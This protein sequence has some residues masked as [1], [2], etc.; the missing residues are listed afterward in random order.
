MGTRHS[1]FAVWDRLSALQLDEYSQSDAH[2]VPDRPQAL[3]M[4]VAADDNPSWPHQFWEIGSFTTPHVTDGDL[5]LLPNAS[6]PI[7]VNGD[8]YL[9]ILVGNTANPFADVDWPVQVFVNDG[10]GHFTDQTNT[11]FPSGVPQMNSGNQGIVA[12]FNGDGR[13]DVF[14]PNNNDGAIE[15]TQNGLFLSSGEHGF[16][17]GTP[18][19]PQTRDFTHGGSATDID[20]DG[21]IDILLNNLGGDG[22][23]P[24][25]AHYGPEF[26]L[27]D[28]SGHFTLD[29]AGR[30]P[31]EIGRD[32]NLFTSSTF[33]D[34]DNDG[35]Q[36]LIL[37]GWGDVGYLGSRINSYLLLNDGTGHFSIREVLPTSK[38]TLGVAAAT[39]AVE[40]VDLNNDGYADLVSSGSDYAGRELIEFYLNDRHGKLALATDDVVI[41]DFN[42]FETSGSYFL[43]IVDLNNDGFADI[44]TTDQQHR[45]VFLNDGS[46]HFKI[47]PKDL[48]PE[49]PNT[50]EDLFY[51][52][53]FGDLNNDGRTDMIAPGSNYG[54]NENTFFIYYGHDMPTTQ[55]GTNNADTILGD[56]DSETLSGLTGD[57]VIFGAGGGDTISG[58]KNDDYINGGVGDDTISGGTQDD[59][60][61]GFDGRDVLNGDAGNDTLRGGAGNDTLNGGDG[62]DLAD[63]SE[64]KM[65]VTV[66]LAI[67]AGQ[68]V[69]I[70]DGTDTL[71][72]IENLLGSAFADKLTGDAHDN[73][74]D[75]GAGNDALNGGDGIDTLCY[76][77]AD[78]GVIVSI[79][80]VTAQVTGGSGKD[81][82][83]NFENLTGSAFDDVLTGSS[84]KNTLRGGAGNDILAGGGGNDMLNGGAGIDVASYAD[85]SAAVHLSLASTIAVAGLGTDTLVSI[86]GL[87]GSKFDDV[88]AGNA[89]VNI[90]GGRAGNDTLSGGKG[91]D[92]LEGGAGNDTLNGG[93]GTDFA[94]Y[95]SATKAVTVDL[96]IKIAQNTVGAGS[97]TLSS[98]EG[99]IGSQF[100][101]TLL[102]SKSNDFLHGGLGNDTLDGRG[103]IDML[104]GDGGDDTII[105]AGG[106]CKIDG[107]DGIDTLN[108]SD[109]GQLAH[110]NLRSARIDFGDGSTAEV[111]NI[112]N[113]IGSDTG[114]SVLNGDI[115]DNVLMAGGGDGN[116]LYGQLGADTLI[117]GGGSDYF[118]YDNLLRNSTPQAPD[119][120]IGLHQSNGGP[121]DDFIDLTE[122]DANWTKDGDQA[123]KIVSGFTHKAGQLVRSYDAGKDLT[124]FLLD[125]NGDGVADMQINA[126]GN[127]L[128]FSHFLL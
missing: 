62:V 3:P 115:Y 89:G 30:L 21:D 42:G 50:R 31:D 36:D 63:Y 123:F 128:D 6:I 108:L 83:S 125:V 1:N 39:V 37:G 77:T 11:I 58:G 110:V 23:G 101:D 71:I 97:D 7:D 49:D 24:N 54:S 126:L 82:V 107:G 44:F 119:L 104:A 12:D 20:G 84:S 73:V 75:G 122:I 5:T 92:T 25:S 127:H 33:L 45:H 61:D 116:R 2:A 10:T 112:E 34:V 96:K 17:D 74:I 93:A 94:S 32:G 28:G 56:G 100:D 40:S 113:V 121:N 120:I 41:D 78:A 67:G 51:P 60:L 99:V 91:D 90:L 118:G 79:A 72:A 57:D 95:A 106:G 55:V 114:G 103:G 86:E 47:A 14:F 15:G 22:T 38:L 124:S 52:V 8:G 85:A 109:C 13:L 35:D 53:S 102:G 59:M 18:Q 26:D 27:N 70:M 9:D 80:T 48:F 4:Q 64:A 16:V 66:S 111:R 69:N 76:E 43:R 46:G 117:G 81:T 87:E 65:G 98:V 29:P 88:L 19:L 68:K 105:V